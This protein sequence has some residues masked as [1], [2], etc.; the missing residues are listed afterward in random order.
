M[1]L[2]AWM[3]ILLAVLTIVSLLYVKGLED[4]G[5]HILALHALG[6]LAVLLRA[7]IHSV[8]CK[9][10]DG[11]ERV[12]LLLPGKQVGDRDAVRLIR[13][14]RGDA[15]EGDHAIRVAKGQRS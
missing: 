12:R 5:S 2:D 3:L 6:R 7:E 11:S 15:E 4:A 13:M 1:P 8:V 14:S 9:S 10:A